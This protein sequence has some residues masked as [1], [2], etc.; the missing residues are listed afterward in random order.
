MTQDKW[1]PSEVTRMLTNPFYT[2]VQAHPDLAVARPVYREKFFA[3]ARTY[4]ET[5]G[6][7]TFLRQFLL[8]LKWPDTWALRVIRVHPR[9]TKERRGIITEDRFVQTGAIQIRDLGIETYCHYLLDNL[10]RGE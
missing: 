2:G 6:A 10:E 5:Q 9:F 3:T 8:L 7:E 4:I 1:T